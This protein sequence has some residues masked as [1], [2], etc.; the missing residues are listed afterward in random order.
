MGQRCVRAGADALG[1][2]VL[3]ALPILWFSQIS[4][5]SWRAC[6]APSN[7]M[8][9]A[10][11]A[12]MRDPRVHVDRVRVVEVDDPSY[13][14]LSLVSARVRAAGVLVG[15]ATWS[16]N[17]SDIGGHGYT[18][19][20]WSRME[21][22]SLVPV[23]YLARTISTS[24]GVLRSPGMTRAATYSQTCVRSAFPHDARAAR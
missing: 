4:S 16:S 20:G 21:Y 18:F 23:N 6:T 11:G 17:F 13:E 19:P 2:V 15:I 10:I 9:L 5:S 14:S 22:S 12:R 3:I 8:A 24:V 7:R 1:A